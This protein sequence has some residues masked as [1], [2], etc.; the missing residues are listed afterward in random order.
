VNLLTNIID[1]GEPDIPGIPAGSINDA[2]NYAF[3]LDVLAAEIPS[4]MEISVCAPASFW[5]LQGFLIQAMAQFLDYVIF[6][7]YDLHGQWDYG[8]LFSDP[9]CDPSGCLRSGVNL[10]ETVNAL[11]MI[12]KAGVASNQIIMGVTSYGRSFQMAT[13]G[14]YT[15]ECLFTGPASGAYA[16]LCTQTSGYIANAEINGI[17]SGDGTVLTPDGDTLQVT[18]TPLTYLDFNSYSNVVV[19]DNNQWIGYMNDT[20]KAGRI[21]L[22]QNLNLGGTTDWAIDLQNYTGDSGSSTGSVV[23]VPP[24]IW[25]SSNPTMACEPPCVLVLPPYP[26]GGLTET[27]TWPVLTTTLLSLSASSITVTITTTISVPKFTITDINFQPITLSGTDTSTYEV[28]PV[29][30]IT[31]AS[32]IWTL[33]PHE[34][35]FPPSAIPTPSVTVNV[36]QA[37]GGGGGGVGT[38]GAQSST[39]VAGGFGVTFFPTSVPI[40]IQPQA[41]Y[42]ITIPPLSTPIPPVTVSRGTPTST[43]TSGCGSRDCNI[44]GCK[45]DCGVFGCDGGCNIFGCGGGCG[46]FGCIGDCF[47]DIC[48]GIDCLTGGCGYGVDGADGDSDQD[49]D[50]DDPVTASACTVFISSWST[51]GMT[52]FSTTTEV[53]TNP[54]RAHAYLLTLFNRLDARQLLIAPPKTVKPQ[55]L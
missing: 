7:T 34:A 41:T 22:Y 44:F 33:G 9:G 13:A 26:M 14:C 29:Q 18:G 11:S 16:G 31:P 35:T 10:T 3:A 53:R 52:E 48:G 1:P 45:P 38:S 4:G 55:L 24:S 23:L 46:P 43:C 20:N 50:C 51:A 25:T 32:F 40:T 19:Y 28:N 12:T 37:G 42:S 30:S 49:E 17:I 27:I 54:L 39:V 15:E 2:V 6:M 36:G 47:L 21:T 5:Y 8:N